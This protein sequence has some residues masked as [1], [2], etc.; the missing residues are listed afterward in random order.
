MPNRESLSLSLSEKDASVLRK[1]LFTADGC[2]NFAVLFCGHARGPD[3]LRL[4]VREWWPA[5]RDA[6]R[7]RLSYHLEITPQFLN[8]VVDHAGSTGLSPVVVHSHPGASHA[9][10]SPSDDFGESRLL[11]VLAQLLPRLT[12]AS[13][14][15]ALTE[16][17]GRRLSG[18]A[19][20]PMASVR[21]V[22][23]GSE[24]YPTGAITP[25]HGK[26]SELSRFDRQVRAIGKAGQRL[27][28]SLRVGIVGVGGTGSA[29]GEQ[30]VRLGIKD[31]RLIDPDTLDETNLSRVWGSYP[32][33]V[34]RP[35]VEILADHLGAISPGAVIVPLRDTV[36]RQGV[37]NDLRDRDLI[38]A[39]TDNHWSRAVLNR[40]AHQYL[41][42]VVDMGV[43]LDARTG[44]VTAAGAQVSLVGDGLTCLRCSGLVDPERVRAESMPAQER[45]SLASEGYI[46]GVDDPEPS[47]I[48]LNTSVAGM[49]VTT[50][51]SIFTNLLGGP[52]PI[53]L[54][55]DVSRGH[56]FA[57]E[58]RHDTEC[59]VCSDAFGV[60][61]LGD[62]QP[63][64]AYD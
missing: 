60:K 10:Y 16:I 24:W 56:V 55:Y 21:V 41:I 62:L 53:Q 13:V 38:F 1:A 51:V 33:D 45:Q 47:I 9:E 27:L 4:L 18:S 59:D 7:E 46:Q 30:A 14:L 36:T 43:R 63:V 54:R 37:L 12:P 8:E 22:G 2:E 49:A 32:A 6:Y 17:R 25:Q 19:F 11:P 15:F 44:R 58:P 26:S 29:V 40:F 3:W 31:L 20:V 48:S 28:T 5:P 23:Q 50:G 61:G 57:A 52:P 34:G 64:S 42:P 35:K 39:C